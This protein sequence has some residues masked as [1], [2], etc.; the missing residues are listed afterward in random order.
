MIAA[1]AGS[2]RVEPC[3]VPSCARGGMSRWW[4]REG[5]KPR[6]T[7]QLI[8]RA[9]EASHWRLREACARMRQGTCVDVR[10]ATEGRAVWFKSQPTRRPWSKARVSP[11]V[12]WHLWRTRQWPYNHVEN[13]DFCY[14]VSGGPDG[15]VF[16]EAIIDHVVRKQYYGGHDRAWNQV[17]ACMEEAHLKPI[18]KRRFLNHPETVDRPETG[19]VLA[20]IAYPLSPRPLGIP[21]PSALR[22]RQQGWALYDVVT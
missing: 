5:C 7:G 13:G 16:A 17:V 21:R 4:R 3:T 11:T 22:V 1:F 15:E 18:S 2:S 8:T 19:Y 12:F 9:V 6:L 14:L 10:R 20:L